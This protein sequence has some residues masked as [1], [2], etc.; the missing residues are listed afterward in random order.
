MS[1]LALMERFPLDSES[2][3]LARRAQSTL[4]EFLSAATPCTVSEAVPRCPSWIG[5]RGSLWNPRA[6]AT[7]GGEMGAAR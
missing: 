2:G 4:L 7:G 6:L 5:C 3:H 1:R